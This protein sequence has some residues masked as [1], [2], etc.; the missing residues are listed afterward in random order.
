[1]AA[2]LFALSAVIFGCGGKEER[3]AAHMEKGKAYYAQANYDKARIELKNVLQIDPKSAD[4]YY[5]LGLIDEEEQN[6]QGAF[7]D[8]LKAVELNPESVPAKV[9]LGRVY[10]FSGAVKE[11]EDIAN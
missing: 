10:V 6:W 9:K 11:A 5:V 2:L 3:K 1:M 7:N 4:A 8:Y